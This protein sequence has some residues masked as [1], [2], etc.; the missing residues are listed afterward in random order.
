M[1]GE[2]ARDELS[3]DMA[4]A[5]SMSRLRC[6]DDTAEIKSLHAPDRTRIATSRPKAP[7]PSLVGETDTLDCKVY[8]QS[9]ALSPTSVVPPL[10]PVLQ[11]SF[12]PLQPANESKVALLLHFHQHQVHGDTEEEELAGLKFL[13]DDVNYSGEVDD[14]PTN[15][16]HNAV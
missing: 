11:R 10:S 9:M 3:R 6:C 15:A 12:R 2:L 1:P 16:K 13:S 14:N 4:I 5:S 7:S 8:P